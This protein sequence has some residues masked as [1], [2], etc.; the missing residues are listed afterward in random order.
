MRFPQ[1]EPNDCPNAMVAIKIPISL[2]KMAA[3]S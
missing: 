2:D 1:R 3:I